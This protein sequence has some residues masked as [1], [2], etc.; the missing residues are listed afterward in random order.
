M[1]GM[2]EA[3]CQL[4]QTVIEPICL[5]ACGHCGEAMADSVYDSCRFALKDLSEA[6]KDE[7]C[8]NI[9]SIGYV[10]RMIKKCSCKKFPRGCF[11]ALEET[12]KNWGILQNFF[13]PAILK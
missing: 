1:F 11:L 8:P 3:Q 7:Y 4:W 9:I 6:L 2:N 12:Y 5:D 13:L 10:H